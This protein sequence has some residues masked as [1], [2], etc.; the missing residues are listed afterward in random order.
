MKTYII[1]LLILAHGSLAS[2]LPAFNYYYA[3]IYPPHLAIYRHDIEHIQNTALR[4]AIADELRNYNQSLVSSR[5]IINAA[6]APIVT[7]RPVSLTISCAKGRIVISLEDGS[8]TFV[9][10]TPDQAA[11]EFWI[12]VAEAFP[13]A[14]QAIISNAKDK[15]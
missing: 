8:V 12:K 14:Q 4:K 5:F 6:R 9:D 13:S 7:F 15:P 3:P 2:E 1:G 10:C 11:R